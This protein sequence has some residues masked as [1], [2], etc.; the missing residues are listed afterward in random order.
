MRDADKAQPTGDRDA[1]LELR[2]RRRVRH[3]L[4]LRR[5]YADQKRGYVLAVRLRDQAF[6]RLVSSSSGAGNIPRTPVIQGLVDDMVRLREA[7]DRLAAIWASFRT[8]RLAL[9]RDLGVLPYENWDAFYADLSAGHGAAE[10]APAAAP[11]VQVPPRAAPAGPPPPPP[12]P[13]TPPAPRSQP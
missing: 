13:P 11:A 4:E 3:L 8:E 1:A 12:A 10:P 9:Y 7:E 6:E 2:V 5:D